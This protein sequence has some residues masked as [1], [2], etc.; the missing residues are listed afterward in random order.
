MA[1]VCRFGR[2]WICLVKPLKTILLTTQRQRSELLYPDHQRERTFDAN[3]PL[4]M[5]SH[6]VPILSCCSL[7]QMWNKW[8]KDSHG[9]VPYPTWV[10]LPPSP[11]ITPS[12]KWTVTLWETKHV[13]FWGLVQGSGIKLA[14]MELLMWGH[15]R[16]AENVCGLPCGCQWEGGTRWV[17]LEGKSSGVLASLVCKVVLQMKLGEVS[18]QT[19]A[20]SGFTTL[21]QWR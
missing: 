19:W 9:F 10:P 17:T 21:R 3:L 4:T 14:T 16:L 20:R 1:Q 18:L 12:R 11:H 13:T 6:A 5:C 15:R 7:L 2:P 8:R